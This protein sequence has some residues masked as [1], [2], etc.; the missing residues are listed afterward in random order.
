[1]RPFSDE[2]S[3]IFSPYSVE[4]KIRGGG[5]GCKVR[6]FE[7]FSV[8]FDFAAP[9]LP[10]HRGKKVRLHFNP[11]EPDC[12]AKVVLLEN[13]GPS[14]A[15]AILG[16]A[17]LVGETAQHIRSILNWARDDQQA[18]YRLRQQTGHYLARQ[19]R[20]LG[21]AGR[22]LYAA[23]EHRNGLGQTLKLE[24]HIPTAGSEQGTRPRG[25]IAAV[26][27][28]I[29]TQNSKPNIQNSRAAREA[30]AAELEQFARDHQHII[31]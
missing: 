29:S 5:V 11:R 19:T 26:A 4:R 16:D 30:R 10:L 31:T 1:L 25:Q 23:A 27:P 3:W 9:W 21:S 6:L 28:E 17:T 22:I 14:N 24:K 7:D 8:P 15:G 20:A 12:T 13:S 2:L 18:G